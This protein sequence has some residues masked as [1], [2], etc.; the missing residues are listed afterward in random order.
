MKTKYRIM[1]DGTWFW[2][3]K[4]VLGMWIGVDINGSAI[5]MFTQT[6]LSL[7]N[8]EQAVDKFRNYKA[9]IVKEY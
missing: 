4:R 8:A 7:D 3:E 6:Y 5:N 9:T 2:V 1:S